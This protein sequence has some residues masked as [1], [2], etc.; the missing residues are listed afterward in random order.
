MRHGF[1]GHASWA[2]NDRMDRL[3]A[4]AMRVCEN[5]EFSGPAGTTVFWHHRLLH[6]PSTNRTR[7][8]RH[9]LIADFIQSDWEERADDP[10]R[11]DMWNG[12]AVGDGDVVPREVRPA[13]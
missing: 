10:I 7:N 4:E 5:V 9:A 2:F 1:R 11:S 3:K 13:A 6:T 12:W 8:V